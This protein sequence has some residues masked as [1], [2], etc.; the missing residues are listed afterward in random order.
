MRLHAC[1]TCGRDAVLTRRKLGGVDC[2]S[3]S[4]LYASPSGEEEEEGGST[5]LVKAEAVTALECEAPQ[6]LASLQEDQVRRANT[7]PRSR[8]TR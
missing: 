3:A 1:I 4:L 6:H 8:R 7:S 5:D 2:V